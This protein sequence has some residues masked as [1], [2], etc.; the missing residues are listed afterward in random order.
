MADNNNGWASALASAVP[1]VGDVVNNLFQQ[2]NN[3]KQRQWT[4]DMYQ[5]QKQDNLDFW[6]QQNSYNSPEQQMQRYAKAGLNPA[7][8]Y[9]NG[10][11]SAGN[12]TSAPD[13]PNPQPYHPEAPRFN[14]P[15]VVDNYYDI[16]TR[17]QNLSNQAQM[18]NNLALDAM[19]KLQDARTKTMANDYM[20]R[21]GYGYRSN[22][23]NYGN[24]LTYER[25]LDQN[26]RNIMNFGA[27][28][29]DD[30]SI[31]R[32]SVYSLQA[33]GIKI[34]N[35]LRS[36]AL[37]GNRIDNKTKQIR[38]DT[39]ERFRKGRLKDMS[40]KDWLQLGVQGLGL[41]K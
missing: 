19:N 5:R 23:E 38:A 8:I 2:G 12:A 13:A 31:A 7:L 32:D 36:S 33:M 27:P 24:Q 14:L 4:E 11:S 21:E 35:D 17:K 9:G 18:G 26:A 41:F 16:A 39:E 10:T 20:S 34:M 3:R 37:Q 15:N 1:V 6:N 22:R 28:A 25:F 29:K 40:A 30:N